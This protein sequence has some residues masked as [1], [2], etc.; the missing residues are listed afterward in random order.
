M[1]TKLIYK[2]HRKAPDGF[3]DVITC[4]KKGW[5]SEKEVTFYGNC[6]VWFTHDPFQRCD[7]FT[8]RKLT[9]IWMM[10]KVKGEL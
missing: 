4:I 9:D 2:S 3:H 8:E 5:F 1:Y 7:S 10:L 6:T